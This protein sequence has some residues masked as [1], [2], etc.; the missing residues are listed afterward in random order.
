MKQRLVVLI[1]LL[2]A[3][4]LI[5]P[6]SSTCAYADQAWLEFTWDWQQR[7]NGTKSNPVPTGIY[8]GEGYQFGR[9]SEQ[10]TDG[11]G[12]TGIDIDNPQDNKNPN[13]YSV[14]GGIV[15]TAAKRGSYG[16]IIIIESVVGS[17]C[18]LAYYAHLQDGSLRVSEGDVVDGG[19]LIANM[20]N[21]GGNWGEHLHFE[22]RRYSQSVADYVPIDPIPVLNQYGIGY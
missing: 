3:F 21:T 16:N 17:E 4:I 6:I 13:V 10:P 1:I 15:Q 7:G 20:G 18:Y 8:R 2:L 22:I 5:N 12:H 9:T 11:A 14:F 19:T